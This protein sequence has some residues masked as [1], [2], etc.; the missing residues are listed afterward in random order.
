[1]QQKPC[2]S[3]IV[4]KGAHLLMQMNVTSTVCWRKRKRNKN[5]KFAI[6]ERHA[7]TSVDLYC[8]LS[9]A[10]FSIRNHHEINC[11]FDEIQFTV[12][13]AVLLQ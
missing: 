12:I 4:V 6:W 8:C 13:A 5:E 2:Y 9:L 11:S 10:Y 7:A 3:V 1:M